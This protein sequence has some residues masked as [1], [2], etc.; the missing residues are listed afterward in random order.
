AITKLRPRMNTNIHNRLSP[1]FPLFRLRGVVCGRRFVLLSVP[2]H[3]PKS[4]N[5][6]PRSGAFSERIT[7]MIILQLMAL[8]IVSWFAASVSDSDRWPQF[9]GPQSAGVV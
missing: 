2:P 6:A 8:F 5:K 9:R 3:H 7:H 4:P 1:I